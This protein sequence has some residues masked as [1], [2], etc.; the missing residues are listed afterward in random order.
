MDLYAAGRCSAAVGEVDD[1]TLTEPI[2]GGV[3]LF[4]ETLEA[5]RQPMIPAG[6]PA[7]AVHPLL[8]HDP[9]P[10][11]GHNEAVQIKI[12]AILH[13]RAVHFRNQAARLG[14]GHSVDADV[15]ADGNQLF[16]GLPRMLAASS[17]DMNA[18]LVA[19]RS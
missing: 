9:L 1:F 11:I 12:E 7:L 13:G 15:V 14:E 18:K 16:R 3:R 2:N 6:L 17:A 8:N 10:V 4:D 19:K 5:F